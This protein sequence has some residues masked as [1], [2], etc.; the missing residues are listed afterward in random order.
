MCPLRAPLLVSQRQN[1]SLGPPRANDV[2][3]RVV[4][5]HPYLCQEWRLRETNAEMPTKQSLL[6]GVARFSLA[7]A[8]GSRIHIATATTTTKNIRVT[9]SRSCRNGGEGGIR[10]HGRVP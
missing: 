5:S 8:F 2:W 3:V 1:I 7:G 10:T 6:G 4:P 9:K